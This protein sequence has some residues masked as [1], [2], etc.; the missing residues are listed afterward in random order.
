VLAAAAADIASMASVNAAPK[1][2]TVKS[3][4]AAMDL[5]GF[6]K[7]QFSDV[8]QG[9]ASWPAIKANVAG[10]VEKAAAWDVA[11]ATTEQGEAAKAGIDGV[12]AAAVPFTHI[13][14][15]SGSA[16]AAAEWVAAAAAH[17][18]AYAAFKAKEAEAA[19]AAAA[20]A[21]EAGAE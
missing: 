7:A 8:L 11:A 12:D 1:S 15:T 13:A 19:E 18:E 6:D 17:I 10:L 5:A 2:E 21:A 20:A 4:A 9:G 3:L 16:G 14:A